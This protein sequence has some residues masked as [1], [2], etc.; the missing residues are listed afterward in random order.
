MN[1]IWKPIDGYENYQVSNMGNVMNI[2]TGKVLKTHNNGRGYLHVILYD[3]NHNGRTI[4]VHRLVAK[5]FIPNPENLPQINH[6]DECK[7]NNCVEN[8]EWI[9]SED[10]INHGTH[11]MRVGLNNPNRRPIYSVSSTGDVVYY[12]SAREA[13]R[14]YKK[15][16]VIM[17]PS[18]ISSALNEEIYTYMGL[19]WYYQTDKSGI[20]EYYKK[21]NVEK[22]SCKKIYCVSDCGDVKH[23]RSMLSALRFYNLPEH[24]RVYLRKALNTGIKFN[25]LMWFY[26][27]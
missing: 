3:K 1:E 5:A 8:L 18:G 19:A 22:N 7:A 17:T 24:Q 26:D 23:F 2:I 11:N 16:G 10:N 25:D 21:F 6:I 12:D 20:T 4:M 27:T 9:T 14:Y 15:I 13:C